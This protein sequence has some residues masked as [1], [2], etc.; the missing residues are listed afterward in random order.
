LQGRKGAF[1]RRKST[2]VGIFGSGLIEIF[3]PENFKLSRFTSP[4]NDPLVGIPSSPQL[5]KNKTAQLKA[6]AIKN[7]ESGFIRSV[8]ILDPL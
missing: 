5:A 2:F 4:F 8:I 6:A 3:A 1:P 7:V